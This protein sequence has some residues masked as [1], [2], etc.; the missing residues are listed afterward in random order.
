MLTNRI[1]KFSIYLSANGL[2]IVIIRTVYCIFLILFNLAYLW[3]YRKVVAFCTRQVGWGYALPL[4]HVDLP[5]DGDLP[6]PPLLPTP[7]R[8]ARLP[9][10]SLSA[11]RAPFS[12]PPPWRPRP[13]GRTAGEGRATGG[14]LGDS[15][16][17]AFL[18]SSSLWILLHFTPRQWFWIL[19]HYTQWERF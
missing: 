11:Q 7:P 13:P 8:H 16:C 9:P 15:D 17:I 14:R 6:A 19:S 5:A 2:G 1:R 4:L 10:P 12:V 18:N 3:L